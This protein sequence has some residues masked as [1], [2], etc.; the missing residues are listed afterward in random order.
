M[1]CPGLPGRSIQ[2]V[3]SSLASSDLIVSAQFRDGRRYLGQGWTTCPSI[4]I[5]Y[6]TDQ[7]A[8]ALK[9][10]HDLLH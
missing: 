4:A 6:D 1:L 7:F 3:F 8:S 9:R 5:A 2:V 10:I